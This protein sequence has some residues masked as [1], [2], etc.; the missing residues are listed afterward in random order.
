MWDLLK[1]IRDRLSSIPELETVSIGAEIGITAGSCPAARVITEYSEPGK[2]R[3]FDNGAIQVVL[4]MDL[5]NDLPTVYQDSI[6]LELKIREALKD[7][8][9]FT[10]I[11]YDQDS[12]TV[13]KASIMRFTFAGIRNTKVE[14]DTL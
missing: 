13:F 12:V 11:D 2:N 10:R 4:L 7:I 5:K 14:C 9:T 6:T 3:Y 8:V 1:K